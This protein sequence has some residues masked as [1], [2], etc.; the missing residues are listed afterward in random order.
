MNA[1]ESSSNISPTALSTTPPTE[2]ADDPPSPLRA[3]LV[4]NK[5]RLLT[6]LRE[7][8]VHCATISYFGEGDSGSIELVHVGGADG[9]LQRTPR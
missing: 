2:G 3:A 6:A 1:L 9:S 7:A 8:G 4:E 5:L